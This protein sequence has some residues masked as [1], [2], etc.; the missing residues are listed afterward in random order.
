MSPDGQS[1]PSGQTQ[2]KKEQ[3]AKNKQKS[4]VRVVLVF[5]VGSL[6]TLSCGVLLETSGDAIAKHIGMTGVLFGATVL[7]ASTSLPELSTG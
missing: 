7:A 5:A 6:V 2:K 4:T 3:D 1:E